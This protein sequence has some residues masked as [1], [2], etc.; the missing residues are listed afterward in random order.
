MEVFPA[1]ILTRITEENEEYFAHLIP[2]EILRDADYVKLGAL[3]EDEAVSVCALGVHDAMAHIHWIYT[4]PEKRRL[5]GASFLLDAVME[6]LKG[7]A[8]EGIEVDF[9][10]EDDELESF[11]MEREFLVEEERSLY[12]VPLEDIVY[13]P[14]LESLLARRSGEARICPI[15]DV[16]TPAA[17]IHFLQ[18]QGFDLALFRGISKDYSFICLD[19]KGD[20][21]GGIF[22]SETGERD[23]RINYLFGSGSPQEMV[24]LVGAVI[25]AVLWNDR[26]YG[27]LI[28]SVRVDEGLGALEQITGNHRSQY[29]E[30]GHMYAVKLV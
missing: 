24:E 14:Q 11:L 7:L 28:F 12:R 18:E 21:S 26:V 4:D 8:L 1:M 25:D 9:H 16:R 29:Q 19:S 2:E 6:L 3:E 23:L 5:G 30:P 17:A 10:A 20:M 15:N 27:D 13:S 22:L